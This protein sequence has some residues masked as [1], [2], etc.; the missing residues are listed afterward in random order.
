MRPRNIVAAVFRR[1]SCDVGETRAQAIKVGVSGDVDKYRIGIRPAQ[2]FGA[3]QRLLIGRDIRMLRNVVLGREVVQRHPMAETIDRDRTLEYRLAGD[4]F[5]IEAFGDEVIHHPRALRFSAQNQFSITART[6]ALSRGG[7]IA[8]KHTG[9][10]P[11]DDE[12]D[13][14]RRFRDVLG[15]FGLPLHA[16]VRRRMP[17]EETVAE[18]FRIAH[19]GRRS[20]DPGLVDEIEHHRAA[21]IFRIDEDDFVGRLAGRGR[22]DLEFRGV[23]VFAVR[24]L[25]Q[26][27]KAYDVFISVDDAL[28]QSEGPGIGDAIVSADRLGA[29][30]GD[31]GDP[32][33]G[34][35]GGCVGRDE[36]GAGQQGANQG[37]GKRTDARNNGHGTP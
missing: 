20:I 19:P 16:R 18:P 36:E 15:N 22:N 31:A 13:A 4:R 1:R 28:N 2:Q 12:P 26:R 32:G 21:A 6:I 7:G 29:A 30:D 34:R 11:H 5:D 10:I 23:L 35:P 37:A 24:V 3:L 17:L 14:L 33:L 9:E 8:G 27:R 25:G